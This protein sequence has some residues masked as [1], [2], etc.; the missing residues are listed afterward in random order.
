MKKLYIDMDGVIKNTEK[1][2]KRV[3]KANRVFCP[4]SLPLFLLK[5]LDGDYDSYIKS[6]YCNYSSVPNVEGALENIKL[7]QTEYSIVFFSYVN[8]FE[9]EIGKRE[10]A[11]NFN[12]KCVILESKQNI[13][14][15]DLSK[16]ILVSDNV[17]LL[18][19]SNANKR[20]QF[21]NSKEILLCENAD[22]AKD[23]YDLV[24]ILME[25]NVDEMLRGCFCKGIQGFHAT[26]G[27]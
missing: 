17:F 5:N 7:I 22:Y 20:I 18:S 4:E 14:S 2:I 6:V 19:D 23:W 11:K 3:L 24:D 9:E 12:K 8:S 10:F 25:V 21:S 26:S 16:D 15:I 13:S 27:L 1:Y